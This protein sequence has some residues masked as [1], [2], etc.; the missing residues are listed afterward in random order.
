MS[1]WKEDKNHLIK[2]FKLNSFKQITEKLIEIA[3]IADKMDHHPDFEVFNYNKIKFKIQTH[4]HK[5]VTELDYKLA[6]E[7]DKIL[8]L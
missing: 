7:I 3:K 1:A 4:T 2:E 8:S 6:A 5:T